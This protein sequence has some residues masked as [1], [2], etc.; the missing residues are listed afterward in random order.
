MAKEYKLAIKIAGEVENSLKKSAT[1]SKSELRAISKE[2]ARATY[3]MN[4][5]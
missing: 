2:A 4:L 5:A 1:I 3:G